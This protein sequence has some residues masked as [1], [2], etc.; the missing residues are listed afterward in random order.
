MYY[1][2]NLLGSHEHAAEHQEGCCPFVEKLE[3]PIV[4]GDGVDF[5][6]AAC[7][8]GDSSHE[9]CHGS[10]PTNHHLVTTLTKLM[11]THKTF[12]KCLRGV[13]KDQ[14]IHESPLNPKGC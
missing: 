9:F 8:L 1:G 14:K 4:D 3:S 6:E 5:Q 11:E 13:T 12:Q 10:T 7:D 2:K